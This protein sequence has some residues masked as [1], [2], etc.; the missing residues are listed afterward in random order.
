MVKD[1]LASC[2]Q[3]ASH[4]DTLKLFF[5]VAAFW[6]CIIECYVQFDCLDF[7]DITFLCHKEAAIVKLPCSNS[8]WIVANLLTHSGLS[9]IMTL[10]LFLT[11]TNKTL[12]H[13]IKKSENT[14]GRKPYNYLVYFMSIIVHLI[15]NGYGLNVA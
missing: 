14:M 13:R 6:N 5:L 11:N 12:L 1:R 2:L 4:R 9:L 10:F 8:L 7:S 3:V 15:W